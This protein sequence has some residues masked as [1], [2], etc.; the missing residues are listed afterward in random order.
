MVDG[1]L[2][3]LATVLI[4]QLV[5]VVAYNLTHLS[6]NSRQKKEVLQVSVVAK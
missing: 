6:V 1:N 4:I 3:N 2:G 5:D